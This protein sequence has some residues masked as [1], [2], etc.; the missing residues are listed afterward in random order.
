VGKRKRTKRKNDPNRH[1][2]FMAL[3]AQ[4]SSSIFTMKN[5]HQVVLNVAKR[6]LLGKEYVHPEF[7]K[8]VVRFANK[9]AMRAKE[10]A[11]PQVP[12][13]LRMVKGE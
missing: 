13:T 5:G 1:K 8:E 7:K 6:Y 11:E 3:R 4:D 10:A 2:A 12:T 9:I